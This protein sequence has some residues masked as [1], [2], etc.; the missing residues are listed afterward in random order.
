MQ[1]DLESTFLS[2]TLASTETL[3]LADIHSISAF[4]TPIEERF[5]RITRIKS[6]GCRRDGCQL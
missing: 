5:E 6:Q 4:Y 3:E 1:A 2:R